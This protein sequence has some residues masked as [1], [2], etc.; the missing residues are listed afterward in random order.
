MPSKPVSYNVFIILYI[1]IEPSDDKCAASSKSRGE[2]YLRFLTCANGILPLHALI[3]SQISLFWL[4]P[5]EPV[6]S[7]IP[8]YGLFTASRSFVT[9]SLPVIILGSP[10]IGHAVSSG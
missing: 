7:V 3:I 6:Q 4:E 8:L 1:S 10:N 9:E 2:L 5:N